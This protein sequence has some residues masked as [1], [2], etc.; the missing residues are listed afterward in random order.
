LSE[1]NNESENSRRGAATG[2]SGQ[3]PDA[4]GCGGQ[5]RDAI[6]EAARHRFFHYGFKK[7]TIDEIAMDAGVGKGTVY[8]YFDNKEEIMLTIAA[9]VKRNITEQ[10]RAIAASPVTPPEEKL[11][12]MV[13]TAVTSVHDAVNT[14]AHGVEIVDEMLRPRIMACGTPEREAQ[15]V[16]MAEVLADGVRRG[17][18]VLSGDAEE[19]A[20]HLMLAMVSF[21]PPYMNP[22]HGKAKCRNDLER[23]A[24]AMLDFIFQG[25][26]RRNV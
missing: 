25:I 7:T 9:G 6:L 13:M 17:D 1:E 14:T 3:T 23:R 18:F 2:R 20:R 21:F 24:N 11:R 15:Y 12:R 4:G 8:L 19:A 26:R 16:L 5:T 22:C 10:M